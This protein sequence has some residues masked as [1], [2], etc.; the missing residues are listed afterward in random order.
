M[1]QK[2]KMKPNF[3]KYM[4]LRKR[5]SL[6]ADVLGTVFG[7]LADTLSFD[8]PRGDDELLC[9]GA[10]IGVDVVRAHKEDDFGGN[11]AICLVLSCRNGSGDEEQ[12]E[13]G[14]ANFIEHLE[15]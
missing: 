13:P 10:G 11:I 12:N 5:S 7:K 6:L 2:V 4:S 8:L 14:N 15:V 3:S 1:F 9:F